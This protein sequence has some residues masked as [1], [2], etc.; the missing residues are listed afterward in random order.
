MEKAKG[1]ERMKLRNLLCLMSLGIVFT[2]CGLFGPSYSK[3]DTQN[4][5]EFKSRDVLAVTESAN[6]PM[7]AWWEKFDDA[8]LNSLIESA[9]KN[10]NNIQAAVGNV[11]AAQGYLRQ[12]QFAWIP[13]AGV[14]AGYN[15][16]SFIGQGYNFQATP[17]YSLNIFLA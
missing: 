16:R 12:V 6:L 7:M 5:D 8:Q 17:T 10:N 1:Y 13:T 2:G 3:P 9:L 15:E 11:V 4:P 14:N